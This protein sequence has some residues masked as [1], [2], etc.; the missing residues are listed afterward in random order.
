MDLRLKRAIAVCMLAVWST[1]DAAM[2]FENTGE[3]VRNTTK[4][5]VIVREPWT[6]DAF[7]DGFTRE[8]ADLPF[9]R[10]YAY[11]EAIDRYCFPEKPDA[12]SILR[13][14]ARSQ[15]SFKPG[16]LASAERDAADHLRGEYLA[17]APAA[18]F[19]ERTV[20]QIPALANKFTLLMRQLAHAKEL[21]AAGH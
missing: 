15:D 17:C 9:I 16:M 18:K 13:E 3:P 10:A 1:A 7:I 20:A 14:T 8:I 6:A 12:G 11:S 19:V 5:V 4:P 21:K 2:A